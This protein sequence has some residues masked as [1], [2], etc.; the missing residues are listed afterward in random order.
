MEQERVGTRVKFPSARRP[1]TRT[2]TLVMGAPLSLPVWT[3]TLTWPSPTRSEL[4]TV[5]VSGR[6]A[7]MA[8]MVLLSAASEDPASLTATRD[9]LYL[10]PGVR[11]VILQE[12]AVASVVHPG[13]PVALVTLNPVRGRPPVAPAVQL[14]VASPPTAA[15]ARNLAGLKG[16]RPTSSVLEAGEAT[17]VPVLPVAVAV[18]V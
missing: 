4:T 18:K 3:V 10:V 15:V 14:R 7:L 5:G 16:R 11:P 17:E 8:V 6:P 1:S 9:Q 13:A 12:V 2:T